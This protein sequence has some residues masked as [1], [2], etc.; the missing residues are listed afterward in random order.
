MATG[1]KQ[2]DIIEQT[3]R[4]EIT[5]NS[6]IKP[7]RIESTKIL[8]V[9]SDIRRRRYLMQLEEKVQVADRLVEQQ[10]WDE[11][12]LGYQEVE[13]YLTGDEGK[14]V[15]TEKERSEHTKAVR[16]KRNAISEHLGKEKILSQIREAEASGEQQKMVMAYRMALTSEKIT[17]TEKTVYQKKIDAIELK[18]LVAEAQAALSS[19]QTAEAKRLFG[20]VLKKDPTNTIARSA[21]SNLTAAQRTQALLS[22]AKQAIL[23]RNYAQGLSLLE[24]VA[25][26]R[27]DDEVRSLTTECRYELEMAKARRAITTSD[28][29]GALRHLA[30]AEQ[31]DPT[32]AA[33]VST[34]RSTIQSQKK[35]G[36]LVTQIKA[37]LK[38]EEWKRTLELI[39]RARAIRDTQEL[40]D[41]E[42]RTHYGD[43]LASGKKALDEGN[44][45]TA[46]WYFKRAQRF[47]DTAEIKRL[48]VQVKS[49]IPETNE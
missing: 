34:I 18:T 41:F 2:L 4:N 13:D 38:L 19:G 46:R 14:A 37:S 16:R 22:A 8:A 12:Q 3:L 49:T 5:T 20:E 35:Y 28:T 24:K 29:S 33:Q 1:I 21:L 25:Q 9:Y 36:E 7:T 26:F 23:D 39:T 10:A 15:L 42:N 48:L 31:I 11:A 32:K 30:S 45:D 6:V 43:L 44:K 17:L 27:Q 47:V 40:K